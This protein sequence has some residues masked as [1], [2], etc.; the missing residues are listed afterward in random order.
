MK[1]I[2]LYIITGVAIIMAVKFY[3]EN[4]KLKAQSNAASAPAPVKK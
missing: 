1:P 3:R 4:R 2:Y